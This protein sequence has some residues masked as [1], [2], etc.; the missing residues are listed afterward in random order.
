MHRGRDARLGKRQL[1]ADG[2]L[3]RAN[4]GRGLVNFR[5][6]HFLSCN[7]TL[8]DGA[9]SARAQMERAARRDRLASSPMVSRFAQRHR[10]W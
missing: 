2:V 6:P 10:D 7:G 3:R 8:S 4:G 5:A 1:T 9:V